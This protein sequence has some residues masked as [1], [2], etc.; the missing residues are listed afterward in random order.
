[1][2]GS[3]GLATEPPLPVPLLPLS[4]LS[5]AEPMRKLQSSLVALGEGV[6]EGAAKTWEA[7]RI[8]AA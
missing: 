4:H 5:L 7:V 3:R 1:V 6:A 8:T 2:R